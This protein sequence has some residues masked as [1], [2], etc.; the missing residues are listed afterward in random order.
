MHPLIEIT[1]VPIQIEMKV[2]HANLKYARG[3]ANME[4]SRD[5]GGLHIKSQPIRVNLDTF[6]A[7]NS[8]LPTPATSI[9]QAAQK[10]HQA[11]Y[12]ATAAYAQQGRMK[13]ETK[14]GQDVI[15]QIAASSTGVGQDV[16]VNIEFLPKAG[17]EIDWQGGEMNIDYQM[18]KL[19]FDWRMEKMHFEF[20]PGDIEISVKQRPEVII[21][22]VGGPLYVPPSA[23]P[24]YESTDV[25]V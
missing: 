16:N 5:R 15:G 21:K 23:D 24:N 3:S 2:N 25:E 10:G 13:M 20:T 1:T 6:E 4:V 9:K 7:R 11:V 12:E 18:D 22:Y 19:N 8:I 14:V 17:P